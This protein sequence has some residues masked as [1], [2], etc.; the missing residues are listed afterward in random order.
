MK[1]IKSPV[2][3]IGYQNAS[4]EYSFSAEEVFPFL[5]GIIP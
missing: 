5:W 2:I 1:K 3:I 4:P